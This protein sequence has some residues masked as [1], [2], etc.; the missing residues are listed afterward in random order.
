MAAW[1]PNVRRRR[2]PPQRECLARSVFKSGRRRRRSKCPTLH[3]AGWAAQ[4]SHERG[5]GG[6]VEY[7]HSPRYA[8]AAAACPGVSSRE[9]S[10]VCGR[11]P[12][13]LTTTPTTTDGRAAMMPAAAALL[14]LPPSLAPSLC[15]RSVG[16][17]LFPLSCP[18]CLRQNSQEAGGGGGR[19]GTRP[20]AR[21]TA[22]GKCRAGGRRT[23][24]RPLRCRR[25]RR[26][27]SEVKF[28]SQ[29][30]I[31]TSRRCLICHASL[32]YITPLLDSCNIKCMWRWC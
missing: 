11:A 25:R 18:I 8:A 9:S 19:A 7:V 27:S 2:R 12:S 16:R 6:V 22:G 3:S 32:G 31:S 14:G 21:C 10:G 5:S 30:Q 23:C 13:L 24:F 20:P 15:R 28:Q 1:P 29:K 26:R 4:P 17:L